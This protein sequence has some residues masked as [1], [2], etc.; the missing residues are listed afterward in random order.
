MSRLTT[1]VTTATLIAAGSWSPSAQQQVATAPATTTVRQAMSKAALAQAK[2]N[3]LTTIQG[4]AITS[5]NGGM[6]NAVVRLRDA[7]FGRIV[8]TQLTDKSGLFA[9]K[10][11][12]P[13][14]YIV[15]IVSNDQ[16]IMAASQILNVDAGQAVSAVVK[17]PFRI[18]PFAGLM[19]STS[20]P[21]ATAVAT[22]AAASSVASVVPTVPVSPVK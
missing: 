15:E 5:T 22:E 1:I 20:T 13:G 18:P 2:K 17:L 11:I 12:D 14:S 19:G 16:S 7:K 21:S 3:A 10:A 8:D 9:F 4:N 6:T